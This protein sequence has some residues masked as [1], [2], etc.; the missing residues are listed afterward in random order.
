MGEVVNSEMKGRKTIGSVRMYFVIR[1]IYN[2][3][4]VGL[5]KVGP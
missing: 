5:L 4:H 2:E 1:G 3:T